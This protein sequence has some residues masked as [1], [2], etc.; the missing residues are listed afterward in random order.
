MFLKIDNWFFDKIF[1]PI[2]DWFMDTYGRGPHW[3]AATFAYLYAASILMK[4]FYFSNHSWFGMFMDALLFL[5]VL[6]IAMRNDKMD[7]N[8][9]SSSAMNWRRVDFL[10]QFLRIIGWPIMALNISDIFRNNIETSEDIFRSFQ[11]LVFLCLL[12][13]ESCETRP[14]KPKQKKQERLVTASNAT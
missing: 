1:Q 4:Q 11:S 10:F 3:I 7:K 6:G 13:F 2:S 9:A 5:F 8:H 12:Y 14:P